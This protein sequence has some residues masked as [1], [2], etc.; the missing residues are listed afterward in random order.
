MKLCHGGHFVC[1]RVCMCGVVL[2]VEILIV[3]GHYVGVRVG[4]IHARV[5]MDWGR[6][7]RAMI[8]RESG[9]RWADR[10]RGVMKV[11]R[12]AM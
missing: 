10:K 7:Q 5:A 8:G 1:V 11:W 6:I 9:H 2:V 12:A 3:V 4:W